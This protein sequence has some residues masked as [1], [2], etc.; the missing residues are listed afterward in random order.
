M[1][2]EHKAKLLA[3]NLGRH[4]SAETREKI[5]AAQRGHIMP[6]SVRLALRQANVGSHRPLS[7]ETKAHISDAL[8]GK[9][10]HTHVVSV[11]VRARLSA[12]HKGVP[13]PESVRAIHVGSHATAE[14][15]AKMSMAHKG[16]FAGSSHWNWKG[17][18]T[19]DEHRIRNS[20]EYAAWRTAVFE[21]DNYTCQDCGAHSGAGHRVT[22][23]AH[24][25]H[26]FAEYPDERFVVANGVTLC[27]ACHN[28]TKRGGRQKS[29]SV[30]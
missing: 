4:R 29:I 14:T 9:P 8:K 17:G 2:A 5:A 20:P 24:H 25:V 27:L 7:A 10:G 13:M 21:R 23:E 22:L 11:E 12:A 6:E 3:A 15:K 19:A 30:N 28:K 26:E 1:T 18:I 16:L